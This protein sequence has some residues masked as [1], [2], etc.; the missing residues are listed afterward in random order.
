MGEIYQR[1]E[2]QFWNV[3]DIEKFLGYIDSPLK[4]FFCFC[5]SCFQKTPW[6]E[7]PQAKKPGEL[8]KIDGPSSNLGKQ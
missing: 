2:T 7:Y 6:L 4:K 5:R 8:T 3:G 1:R